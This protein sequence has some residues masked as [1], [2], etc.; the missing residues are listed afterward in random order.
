M[1]INLY[2]FQIIKERAQC[3]LNSEAGRETRPCWPLLES[4]IKTRGAYLKTASPFLFQTKIWSLGRQPL[5]TNACTESQSYSRKVQ[6]KQTKKESLQADQYLTE[7]FILSLLSR[8]CSRS[9]LACLARILCSS[10]TPTNQP[11]SNL[12]VSSHKHQAITNQ[13][14]KVPHWSISLNSFPT[15]SLAGEFSPLLWPA[16]SLTTVADVAIL[17]PFELIFLA[18]KKWVRVWCLVSMERATFEQTN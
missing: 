9:S 4:E 12:L 18:W 8:N 7:E 13:Q 15:D 2:D 6:N 1:T 16:R 10:C 17:G 5:K 11:K 14:Q 3:L